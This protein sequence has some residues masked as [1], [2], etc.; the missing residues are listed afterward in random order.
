MKKIKLFI[1]NRLDTIERF[2][3][4]TQKEFHSQSFEN[5]LSSYRAGFIPLEI[6]APLGKLILKEVED[7]EDHRI[8]KYVFI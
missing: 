4:E 3:Y 2:G 5:L 1:T 8:I 6:K 7:T